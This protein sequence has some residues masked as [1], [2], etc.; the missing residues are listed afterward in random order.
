MT[1]MRPIYSPQPMATANHGMFIEWK[2][3]SKSLCNIWQSFPCLLDKVHIFWEGHKI[4]RNLPLTFDCMYCS[5]GKISQSFVAF[6]ENMNF[7]GQIIS[8]GFF[9]VIHPKNKQTNSSKN[10]FVRLVFGSIRGYQKSFLNYLTFTSR[11]YICHS[12]YSAP[13]KRC[14]VW[15]NISTGPQKLTKM[16]F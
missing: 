13:W 11:Q 3:V 6:S 14:W 15:N 4:L 2:Y 1:A 12:S 8:K 9:G 5:K 7:K 10:K 16:S